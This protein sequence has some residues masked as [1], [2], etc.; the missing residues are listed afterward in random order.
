MK[1]ASAERCPWAAQ[2]QIRARPDAGCPERHR[3]P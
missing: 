3:S 2:P 1:V